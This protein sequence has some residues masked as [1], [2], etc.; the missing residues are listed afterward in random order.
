MLKEVLRSGMRE[1]VEGGLDE[2]GKGRLKLAVT[3]YFKAVTQVCDYLIFRKY[4]RIPSSHAD[5]F[6]M[7]E[8]GFPEIYKIVDRIFGIYRDTYSEIVTRD[9][10]RVIRNELRKIIGLAGLEEDLKEVVRKIQE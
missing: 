8:R 5:R 10:C 4:A 6:R 1:F 9:S 2:E 3:A 7:L